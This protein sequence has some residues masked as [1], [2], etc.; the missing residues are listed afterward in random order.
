MDLLQGVRSSV[1][2]THLQ[3]LLRVIADPG[4]SRRAR[5]SA[6]AGLATV[7][8]PRAGVL[9]LEPAWCP[10][11]AG[12]FSIGS[13]ASDLEAFERERPRHTVNLPAYQLARYPVTN[14]QWQRFVAE[15]GYDDPAW[16][17]PAGWLA[18]QRQGWRAPRFW[19][20]QSWPG[21]EPNRPVVGVSWYEAMAYSAWLSS[22]LAYSVRLC[23][24]A[25]WEKGARGQD[26]RIYPWGHG[27]DAERVHA[28]GDREER[29]EEA[30]AP[31][32]CYPRGAS[33]W[34][35]DDMVGNTYAWTRSRWGP[36]K[37]QPQFGYPYQPGDGRE[38]PESPDFR[39]VRGGAWS[40]PLRNARCAY[41]GK[42]RPVEAFNN[43]GVRLATTVVPLEQSSS[44]A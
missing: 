17:L 1:H 10:I 20:D 40:F 29:I 22:R 8:D 25:E 43:L 35:L 3:D 31:V 34:G 16:W 9:S 36:T 24:E 32:G 19:H 21:N 15:G 5:L 4:A 28:P 39:F 6:G 41:R 23:S 7:G 2:P 12:P 38:E 37:E 27:L 26:G 44:P 11:P 33:P 42:D 13:D 18:R 30:P 14:G